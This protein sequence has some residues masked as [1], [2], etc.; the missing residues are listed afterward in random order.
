MDYFLVSAKDGKLKDFT[1][2]E[3]QTM[4]T[5]GTVW[6]ERQRLLKE[7]GFQL[8]EAEIQNKKRME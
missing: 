5:T 3:L 6:P 4:D 7:L 8:D 2:I 1:G